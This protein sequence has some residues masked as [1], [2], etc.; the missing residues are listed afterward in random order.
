MDT[1]EKIKKIE[2]E[3]RKTPYHKGTEHHIGKLRAK[4]SVLRN[5]L[6]AGGKKGKGGGAG[7]FALKKFGDATVVFLGFPS[8]GKSTLLNALTNANSKIAPYAF[9]TVSVIPGMMRYKKAYIQLFDLPGIIEEAAK[10]RGRGR[11]ILSVVRNADL[12]IMITEL[13]HEADF[14]KIEDELK[15]I[16]IYLN[17]PDIDTRIYTNM[18]AIAV[19]N[20]I[21][22][23]HK[24]TNNHHY[25][26]ISAR[27]G[28]GLEELKEAI[29]QRLFLKRVYLKR[30]GLEAD[31]E[32]PVIVKADFTIGQIAAK[33]STEMA[34]H[35]KSARIW[36]G[37]AKHP[38]QE[39][40]LA[41]VPQ[42]ETIVHLK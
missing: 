15:V 3:I 17:R 14:I 7:G 9:T 31:M 38:G 30:R 18:P 29:W 5:Q 32:E 37:N 23:V 10:G 6:I 19:I 22:Q 33:I 42:D 4:L 41:F 35:T 27:D 26:Y 11:E 34:A 24:P 28:V 39:V 21:D 2:E 40:S 12:I 8:V 16:G 13:G 20:K 1:E 36:G 25:V